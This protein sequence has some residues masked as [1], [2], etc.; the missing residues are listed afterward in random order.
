M[1]DIV[2]YTGQPQNPNKPGEPSRWKR[3]LEYCVPWLSSKW[4]MA[5]KFTNARLEEAEI[6]NAL[7]RE[8]LEKR[9]QE[10][11]ILAVE[12]AKKKLELIEQSLK[13]EKEIQKYQE[14]ESK[15]INVQV[16]EEL[17]QNLLNNLQKL[18]LQGG[19]VLK[20]ELRRNKV[21]HDDSENQ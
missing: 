3:F 8:E 16:V 2:E 1:S 17:E 7:K 6:N 20:V 9:R 18:R 13:V 4:E 21:E 19:G 10:T 15:D 11:A 5:D 14:S 12:K